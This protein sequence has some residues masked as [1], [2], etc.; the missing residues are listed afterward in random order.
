MR[1]TLYDFRSCPD[2]DRDKRER[3]PLNEQKWA[4]VRLEYETSTERPTLRELADKHQISRSTIFKRAAREKWKQNAILAEATTKQIDRKMEAATS[5]A[6]QLVAK[7]VVEDLQPWIQRE[8]AE[9]IKRA[10]AMGKR[11]FERI[12]KLWEK[13]EPK[14]AKNESFAA[15]TLERHD[16]IVQRNL[17]MGEGSTPGT[18]NLNILAGGRAAIQIV[19][20]QSKPNGPDSLRPGAYAPCYSQRH[21]FR[22]ASLNGIVRSTLPFESIM[23]TSPERNHADLRV[24]DGLFFR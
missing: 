16:G 20:P 11:G 23:R 2:N 3:R 6:A 13:A 21:S 19:A 7:Q 24:V 5:E 9:H 10:V 1:S 18:L 17:G 4:D 14:D 15:A 12:E 8:K 22:S